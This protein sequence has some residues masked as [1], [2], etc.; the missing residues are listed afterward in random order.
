MRRESSEALFGFPFAR[1][2]ELMQRW[3]WGQG[4]AELVRDFLSISDD[5]A[6]ELLEALVREGYVQKCA[7]P[8]ASPGWD[9]ELTAKGTNLGQAST[10]TQLS[11]ATIRRRLHEIIERMAQVNQDERFFVGVQE[12]SIFGEY[13]TEASEL[14]H[15]DVR[16]TTYRKVKERREFAHITERAARASGQRFSNE[17]ELRL[18]PENEVKSFLQNRSPV[19]RFLT[20]T[21]RARDAQTP[22]LVIFQDRAPVLGWRDL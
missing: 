19:Y 16:Y 7:K 15:L 11:R 8:P 2:H 20:N 4:G 17:M 9:Y 3:G 18:W 10:G 22:R 1:I 6:R 14:A 5:A 13:V 12:A 21:E